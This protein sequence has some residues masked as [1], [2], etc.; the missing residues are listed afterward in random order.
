MSELDLFERIIARHQE[1]FSQVAAVSDIKVLEPSSTNLIFSF[2]HADKKYVLKV[3]PHGAMAEFAVMQEASNFID[4]PKA[5]SYGKID[6]GEYILMEYVSGDTAQ[7][8]MSAAS[9][10]MKA[11]FVDTSAKILARLHRST[12]NIRPRNRLETDRLLS[13]EDVKNYFEK[14][15]I[16]DWHGLYA[17]KS[18]SVENLDEVCLNHGDFVPANIIMDKSGV[19]GIIDWEDAFWDSP[20]HDLGLTLFVYKSLGFNA[21][22]FLRTYVDEWSKP[23]QTDIHSHEYI[24]QPENLQQRL[25]YYE[26]LAAVQFYAFGLYAKQNPNIEKLVN[27]QP[28][29]WQLKAITSADKIIA[30]LCRQI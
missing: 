18:M 1:L 14:L 30:E 27:T 9:P 29:S 10:T 3:M 17:L 7:D 13:V 2:K 8:L 22:Q 20:L 24:P 19:R 28:N 16:K 12:W 25:P 5:L 23:I 15:G 6:N 4:I 21:R 11:M 26:T